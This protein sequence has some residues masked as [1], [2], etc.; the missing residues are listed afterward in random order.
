MW[1][2]NYQ[3]PKFEKNLRNIYLTI[4]PLFEELHTYVRRALNAKYGADVVSL[5]GPIPM[6]VLGNVWAQSW[7][8]VSGLLDFDFITIIRMKYIFFQVDRFAT[9]FPSHTLPDVTTELHRQ[10]YT[11]RRMYKMAERFFTS[12]GLPAMTE[13]VLSNQQSNF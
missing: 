1:I 4:R 7:G 12:M 6:H 13:F 2:N 10:N 11:V 8:D 3:D 9:P 5:D